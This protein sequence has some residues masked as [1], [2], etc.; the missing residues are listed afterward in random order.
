M[1]AY[2][3]EVL[4]ALGIRQGPAH[5]EL[6]VTGDG[7]RLLDT[8]ARLSGL[9]N[10]VA[11]GLATGA[12]QVGLTIDCYR[13]DATVLADRPLRYDRRRHARCMNLIARREVPLPAAA[14]REGGSA[15]AGLR[16]R[17]VPRQGGCVHAAH[18]RPEFLPRSV[19]P[20]PRGPVRDR[21]DVPDVA[22]AGAGAAMTAAG[23]GGRQ[24]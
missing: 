22:D 1:L 20:G 18:S 2:V 12:D 13:R 15:P 19:V 23:L 4:D 24:R 14:F 3:A 9:A 8:G 10:P 21:T 17:P 6:L 5:T 11:V 7:P 16:E